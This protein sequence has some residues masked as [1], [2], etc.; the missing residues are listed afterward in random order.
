MTT[1]SVPVFHHRPGVVVR[2]DAASWER[3]QAEGRSTHWFWS[4]TGP[5]YTRPDGKEEPV[6]DGILG[7]P[8]FITNGDPFNLTLR[9]LRPKA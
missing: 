8:A 9:N 7:V 2:V 3:W 6:A 5:T 1:V 4:P